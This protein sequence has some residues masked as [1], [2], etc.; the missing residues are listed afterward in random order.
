MQTERKNSK[1]L[2]LAQSALFTAVLCILSP[3]AV[4]IGPVPITLALFAVMLA[5]VVLDWKRASAAVL[6]YIRLGLI[7]L[8]VFSGGKS[9]FGVLAGPTGGYIWSYLPMAI[10]IAALGN[11]ARER[12]FAEDWRAFAACMLSLAVCYLLGT[13]QFTLTTQSDWPSALTVCVYP[14]ILFDVGKAACAALLGVRVRRSL[15]AAGLL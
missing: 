14:F 7:G 13:F 3:L 15:R 9:G 2:F 10:I 6:V 5:G 12:E 11:G 8:P 4:P 1:G